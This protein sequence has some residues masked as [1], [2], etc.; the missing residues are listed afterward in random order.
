MPSTVSL[1][2]TRAKIY[3]ADVWREGF[4]MS[5]F[6]KFA[7]EKGDNAIKVKMDLTKTKGD[8]IVIPLAMKFTGAGVTSDATLEGNEEAQNYYSQEVTVLQRR[9]GWRDT[10]EN[11]NQK[12]TYSMREEAKHFL[13]GRYADYLDDTWM[14]NMAASPTAGEIVWTGSVT[15]IVSIAAT[16]KLTLATIQK[17]KRKCKIHSPI[18]EPIMIDGKPHFVFLAHTYAMRDLWTDTEFLNAHYYANLRGDKNPLI[19]GA[20]VLIDGVLIYDFERVPWATDGASSAY[21]A[22]NM[23]LGKNS[24]VHAVAKP[25]FWR[26]KTF[27][28]ENQHGIAVGTIDVIAKS[29]FNS[30][31]FG[32]IHC[33]TGAAAE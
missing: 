17:A 13:A 2:A 31:D 7:S 1:A 15:S 10:G 5:M 23:L 9:W 3:S 18:V 33:P 16:D 27:D 25:M 21:V 30:K 22:Y 4:E 19:S 26:E 20:E 28:Y 12:I 11:D 32:V 8:S 14:T 29:K 6:S 24:A